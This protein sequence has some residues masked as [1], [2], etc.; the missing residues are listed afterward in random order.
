[1]KKIFQFLEEAKAEL[2]KVNWPSK[3]QTIRYTMLVVA[4]SLAV[5]AF[6]GG[7]DWIF[8]NILKEYFI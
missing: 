1:M 6:L 4:V 5:A 2:M 3:K 7:L 8:S